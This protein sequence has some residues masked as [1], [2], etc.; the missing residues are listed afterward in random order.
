MARTLR[1]VRED[2]ELLIGAKGMKGL[3]EEP[4]PAEGKLRKALEEVLKAKLP[5]PN[6]LI[7]AARLRVGA[8]GGGAKGRTPPTGRAPTGRAGPAM[9]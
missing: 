6:A 3:A 2:R 8:R 5:A 7:E 9:R 1:L 4:A